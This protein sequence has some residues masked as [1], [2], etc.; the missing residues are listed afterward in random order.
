MG[1]PDYTPGQTNQLVLLDDNNELLEVHS[2]ESRHPDIVTVTSSG[3]LQTVAPGIGLLVAKNESGDVIGTEVIIVRPSTGRNIIIPLSEI[4]PVES[5]VRSIFNNLGAPNI[6]IYHLGGSVIIQCEGDLTASGE[7][8]I[9][10]LSE[11]LGSD[12]LQIASYDE[13]SLRLDGVNPSISL[14]LGQLAGD[15]I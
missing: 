11:V 1:F 14:N 12:S 15:I 8:L 2:W 10:A 9:A 3:F 13:N 7:E 6:Q 5:E 4:N